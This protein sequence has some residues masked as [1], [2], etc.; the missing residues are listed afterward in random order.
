M[1]TEYWAP[2][3]LASFDFARFAPGARVL[4]VGCGPGEQLQALGARGCHGVGVEP[5]L[6]EPER[7]IADG[8]RIV[9]GVAEQL[10]FATAEFDGVICKVVTPYTD[11]RRAVH[12]IARV[13]KPGATALVSHHG[14]GYFLKYVLTPPSWKH[15]IYGARTIV[16]TWVYRATGR[17]LPQPLGDTIYQSRSILS[18][19][20][21]AA[22]LAVRERPESRRFLGAPVFIYEVLERR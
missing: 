16:N 5:S 14:L 13:L 22:G 2:Y 9:K 10:P 17:R 7:I 21:A 18:R 20:Y 8:I 3:I 1:S 11:E 4:D 19:Y 12:E 15:V 6:S